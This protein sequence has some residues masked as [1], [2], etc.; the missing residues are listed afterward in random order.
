[1]IKL[2]LPLHSHSVIRS[3]FEGVLFNERWNV[4]YDHLKIIT[5]A[6]AQLLHLHLKLFSPPIFSQYIDNVTAEN[7]S[8]VAVCWESEGVNWTQVNVSWTENLDKCKRA[9]I[10]EYPR[11]GGK[12]RAFT[13]H[14]GLPD[15]LKLGET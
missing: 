13:N 7:C 14:L 9:S 6:L 1:M 5:A 3:Y 8:G 4:K 12:K 2:W 15:P 11:L 10:S